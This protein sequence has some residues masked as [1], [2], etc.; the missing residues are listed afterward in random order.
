MIYSC[1]LVLSTLPTSVTSALLL[2]SN[3]IAVNLIL[4]RKSIPCNEICQG[5]NMKHQ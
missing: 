2:G 3:S 5:T 1:P 4:M